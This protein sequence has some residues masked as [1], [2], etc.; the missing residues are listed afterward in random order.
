MVPAPVLLPWK[1]CGWRSLVQATVHGVAKSWARLSDF[2]S[3]GVSA[4]HRLMCGCICKVC[5]ETE[6]HW[7]Q[8]VS[9]CF[10]EMM[11]KTPGSNPAAGK[12]L[13]GL[14]QVSDFFWGQ[15]SCVRPPQPSEQKIL[16]SDKWNQM[17]TELGM[18][19]SHSL[20]VWTCVMTKKVLFR[21]KYPSPQ[22]F[23]HSVNQ[24]CLL[25]ACG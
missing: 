15:V 3:L 22:Q 14:E 9:G 20:P 18:R 24:E 8:P 17:A 25:V 4:G 2:T 16:G 13:R 6:R 12:W 5:G 19:A 23:V 11:L 21:K 10:W 7:A 1:S